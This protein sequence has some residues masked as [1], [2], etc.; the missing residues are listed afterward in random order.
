MR[1]HFGGRSRQSLVVARGNLDLAVK[2]ASAASASELSTHLFFASQ[3]LASNTSLRRAITD[4]SRD[5][6][7][8]AA[9][10]TDLF[11]DSLSESAI[12]TLT[13]VSALR[14]SASGDLVQVLE[15]LGVEA[16]ASSANIV[17]ELDRVEDELFELSRS[18]TAN[19]ELRKALTSAASAEVKGALITELVGATASDSTTKLAIAL[20]A[21]LRGRSLEAA[22]ADFL[23]ALAARRDRLIAV[24]RVARPITP[25][26][27]ERLLSALTKEVGQPVR[28]NIEV[29]PSV[30]G[31]ISIKYADEL[32]DGTVSNRLASAGR[33]LAGQNA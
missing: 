7:A 2:G 20:V 31:G 9:L 12:T 4:H 17:G 8:K 1:I 11:G 28:I 13:Q 19:F 25:A 6:A 16:Q 18:I 22:F 33:A 15:Q 3:V 5:A 14:W 32:V 24:V 29:D 26:Q 23:F 27:S 10:V 21:H 30:L